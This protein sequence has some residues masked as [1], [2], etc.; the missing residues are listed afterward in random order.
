MQERKAH[1]R[2]WPTRCIKT[3]W[4]SL[5]HTDIISDDSGCVV[6][7]STKRSNA[8]KRRK[9][10]QAYLIVCPISLQEGREAQLLP[11]AQIFRGTNTFTSV[12]WDFHHYGAFPV[13]RRRLQPEVSGITVGSSE[14]GVG[15]R[16]GRSDATN[17]LRWPTGV[18]RD[19]LGYR[20]AL[21]PRTKKG[22][23]KSRI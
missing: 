18:Q 2:F 4:W 11:H 19:D 8:T 10:S 1:T 21:R 16:F 12:Y 6:W 13:C 23:K 14:L 5:D 3:S 15:T 22:N 17:T 7:P 9:Q 20:T